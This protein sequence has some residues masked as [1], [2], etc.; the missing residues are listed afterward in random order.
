MGADS[1]YFQN[2]Q[3][4][5]LL[6]LCGAHISAQ[7]FATLPRL[8]RLQC[9]LFDGHEVTDQHILH[10]AQLQLPSLRQ[11]TLYDTSVSDSA[12]IELCSNYNLTHLTLFDS[13]RITG[14]SVEALGRMTELRELEV[15]YSGLSPRGG[16][17]PDVQQL[18]NMLPE[19]IAL[20]WKPR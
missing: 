7:D 3:S 12:F 20:P 17:T 5:E 14:K 16:V 18:K 19:V 1:S 8:E 10:V 13:R 9:M 11:M 6:D 15:T 4:L 2:L